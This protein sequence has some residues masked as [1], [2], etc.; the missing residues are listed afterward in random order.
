MAHRKSSKSELAVTPGYSLDSQADLIESLIR[1]IRFLNETERQH[2]A[3]ATVN[4][5]K[6][7]QIRALLSVEDE[8]TESNADLAA[9]CLVEILTRS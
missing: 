1:R 2:L 9:G 3:D 7:Q 4:L 5:R 6:L 8:I